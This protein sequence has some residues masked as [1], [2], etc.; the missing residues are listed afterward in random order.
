[1]PRKRA[2]NTNADKEKLQFEFSQAAVDRLD[3]I[4][5]YIDAGTRSEAIRFS[6]KMA[7]WLLRLNADGYVV[8]LE[9]R[10]PG[11]ITVADASGFVIPVIVPDNPKPLNTNDTNKLPPPLSTAK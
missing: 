11:D 10:Q 8:K 1:M 2:D 7:E 4:K 9:K 5:K 6:L 3:A